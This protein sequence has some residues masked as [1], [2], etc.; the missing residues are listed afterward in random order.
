[1]NLLKVKLNSIKLN[2]IS[3]STTYLLYMFLGQKVNIQ[4]ALDY[5][6]FINRRQDMGG[7][8]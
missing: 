8:Q 4:F 6:P 5:G 3:S 7:T 2:F 1:M